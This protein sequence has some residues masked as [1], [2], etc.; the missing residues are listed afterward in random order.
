MTVHKCNHYGFVLSVHFLALDALCGFVN[1]LAV[2]CAQTGRNSDVD[3]S[4]FCAL[5]VH[6]KTCA[7]NFKQFL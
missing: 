1:Q 6:L 5:F 2:C 3:W 7:G 4:A